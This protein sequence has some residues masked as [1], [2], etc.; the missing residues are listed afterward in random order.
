MRNGDDQGAFWDFKHEFASVGKN[1][2]GDVIKIV[3]AVKGRN[4][5]IDVRTFYTDRH[6][7]EL[8]PGKGIAIPA[9]LADEVANQILEATA[10]VDKVRAKAR[11]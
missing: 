3:Y 10:Q 6:T 8:M 9:D 7:G 2:R 1:D 11:R 4:E 5:Y